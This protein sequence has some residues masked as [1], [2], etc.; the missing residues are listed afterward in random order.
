MITVPFIVTKTIK[1]REYKYLRYTYQENNKKS[2]VELS[3]GP[4]APSHDELERLKETFLAKIV[5]KRWI[6]VVDAILDNYQRW[7]AR[8]GKKS[9]EG[10]LED[11]GMRFTCDTNKLEGSTLG[12]PA[13]KGILLHDI[14]PANKPL[15]DV[16]EARSHMAVF[17]EMLAFNGDLSL[18]LIKQWHAKLFGATKPR[19]AGHVRYTAVHIT[20]STHVPP[21]TRAEVNRELDRLFKW[22]VEHETTMHPVLL[23]CIMKFRFVSIHP[24]EDG[25]G[26][27]SRLLMNFLLY[28]AGFPM[29]NIT[30]LMRNGYYRAL[31]RA[32]MKG[33]DFPFVH[34]FF[35]KYIKANKKY[36]QSIA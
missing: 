25:N 21:A 1:G 32:N 10:F 29:F 14:T 6:P 31:E 13:V 7:I 4:T 33:D 16:D 24:F 12:Y 20:G 36:L 17:E 19:I 35:T 34:W 28:R 15:S 9:V 18:A 26:R 23:A 8:F 27:A 30:F 3:I 22:Y 11:F 2:I 5:K